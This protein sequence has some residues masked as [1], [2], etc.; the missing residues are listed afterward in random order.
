MRS[1]ILVERQKT[2]G[3]F[4]DVA[5]AAQS[6][7]NMF[8]ASKVDAGVEVDPCIVEAFDMIASKMGRI[9]SGDETEVDHWRDVIGYAQLALEFLEEEK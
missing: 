3:Q 1:E 6:I 7:K 9:A 2:H 5:E 8:R 4:V